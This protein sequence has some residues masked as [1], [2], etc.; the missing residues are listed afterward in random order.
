MVKIKNL[1]KLIKISLLIL[2]SFTVFSCLNVDDEYDFEGNDFE[3]DVSVGLA[4]VDFQPSGK[5]SISLSVVTDSIFSVYNVEILYNELIDG[6]EIHIELT[7]LYLGQIVRPAFGPARAQIDL[8]LNGKD[9]S[10][11]IVFLS[12]DSISIASLRYY[13]LLGKY[14]LK[15]IK[16]TNVTILEGTLFVK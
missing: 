9:T 3:Y 15:P 14:V 12:G 2:V 16:E 4:H 8:A 13:K 1:R 10:Y 7:D 5:D 11:K 6:N